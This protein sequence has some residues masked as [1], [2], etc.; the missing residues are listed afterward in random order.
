MRSGRHAGLPACNRV[1]YALVTHRMGECDNPQSL[2]Q[3]IHEKTAG[4]MTGREGVIAWKLFRVLRRIPGG[5]RCMLSWWSCAG[6]LVLANVGDIRR[7]TRARFPQHDGCWQTGSV[8]V[9]RICGVSPVRPNTVAAIG[10]AEYGG[11]M[12]ISLR[13]DGL[14]LSRQDSELFLQQFC[15]RLQRAL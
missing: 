11:R 7:R 14:Q 3:R 15:E 4:L 12:T 13:T 8:T 6:T 9:E 1:S 2:L 5:L 10:V